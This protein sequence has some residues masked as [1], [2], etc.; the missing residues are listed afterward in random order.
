MND[1]DVEGSEIFG[2][3][4]QDEHI[5]DIAPVAGPALLELSRSFLDSADGETLEG[6]AQLWFRGFL[7]AIVDARVA[8]GDTSLA[9]HSAGL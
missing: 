8:V 6:V 2:A 3:I 4:S 1:S 9:R 5:H 7:A